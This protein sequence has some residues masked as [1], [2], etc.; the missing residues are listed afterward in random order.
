MALV[1]RFPSLVEL[2]VY[3]RGK[4]ADKNNIFPKCFETKN[5]KVN[6]KGLNS[7]YILSKFLIK[8]YKMNVV[9]INSQRT[10][11]TTN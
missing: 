10:D 4:K 1:S 2:P 8:H 3:A 7:L 6:Y 11:Q 9:R 5:K